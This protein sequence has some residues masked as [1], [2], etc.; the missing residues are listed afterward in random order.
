MIPTAILAG[1]LLAIPFRWRSVAITAVGWAVFVAFVEPSAVG[2]AA[3]LGA[4]NGAIGAAFT[5]AVRH[6]LPRAATPR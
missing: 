1:A 3:L 6:A 5:L 4:A 2:G